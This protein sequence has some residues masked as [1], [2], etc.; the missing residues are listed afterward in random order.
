M[1]IRWHAQ[2][3]AALADALDS[4]EIDELR[5]ILRELNESWRGS[6]QDCIDRLEMCVLLLIRAPSLLCVG[7][8]GM[9]AE[10]A[11]AC[12]IGMTDSVVYRPGT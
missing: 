9:C 4:L 1:I 11:A 3:G 2:G 6:K 5:H 10:K 12:L 7:T 8:Y